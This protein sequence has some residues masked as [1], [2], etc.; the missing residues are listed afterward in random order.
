MAKEREYSVKQ[1]AR[2]D[3]LKEEAVA[4][5]TVEKEKIKESKD[6]K[7]RTTTGT[8]GTSETSG[9]TGT[10][11]ADGSF[12]SIFGESPRPDKAIAVLSD[13]IKD[14]RKDPREFTIEELKDLEIYRDPK[15]ITIQEVIETLKTREVAP[16][17]KPV[18]FKL[19]YVIEPIPRP[20]VHKIYGLNAISRKAWDKQ[21]WMIDPD[22]GKYKV[23]HKLKNFVKQTGEIISVSVSGAPETRFSLVIHNETDDTYF[24]W[25]TV[26]SHGL[27]QSNSGFK[28]GFRSVTTTIPSNKEEVIINDPADIKHSP[29]ARKIEFE[30]PP[31]ST[32]KVYKISFLEDT[33]FTTYNDSLPIYGNVEKPGYKITQLPNPTTTIK[34]TKQGQFVS[35][36]GDLEITHLPGSR[37]SA[38]ANTE[39]KYT[40]DLSITSKRALSLNTNLLGNKLT[41]NHVDGYGGEFTSTEIEGVDLVAS[42]TNNIG[43]VTGTITIGKTG[44]RSSE[45][46]INPS[47]IFTL[48]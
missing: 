39:G 40:I 16:A 36:T 44:L 12:T 31:S 27:Q 33:E 41:S 24:D 4:A 25:N 23:M 1:K 9:S 47:S 17:T 22:D 14:P 18:H 7:K 28:T 10:N 29:V 11:E 30:I 19:N 13:L 42:I 26:N 8:T 35:A 38:N 6:L 15:S 34:F 43:S 20:D 5:T 48:D 45:I 32:E 21:F 46:L 37:L 3:L 2:L